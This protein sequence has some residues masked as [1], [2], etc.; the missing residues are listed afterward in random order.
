MSNGRRR[1]YRSKTERIIGGV[2]GGIA[3]HLALDVSIIRILWL[4][5]VIFADNGVIAYL[6]CWII[7]PEAPDYQEDRQYRG[8]NESEPWVKADYVMEDSGDSSGEE[9][10][11]DMRGRRVIGFGL[12]L[13]GSF[14]LLRRSSVHI[15]GFL[16]RLLPGINW[17]YLMDM[18]RA[19]FWPLLLILLGVYFLLGG[20]GRNRLS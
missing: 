6:I 15:F 8:K 19:V 12:I 7:I 5:L 11:Q 20:P 17:H 16:S 10:G 18:G 9:T 1:L 4:L 2:C 13:L 14:F 3:R